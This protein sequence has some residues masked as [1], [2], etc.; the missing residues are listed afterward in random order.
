M[1]VSTIL[2]E[3]ESGP[4]IDAKT[5]K[6]HALKGRLYVQGSMIF[7]GPETGPQSAAK[8]LHIKLLEHS[9]VGVPSRVVKHMQLCMFEEF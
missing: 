6:S 9:A 1:Q 2:G 3:P 7:G 5:V 8:M 4:Q